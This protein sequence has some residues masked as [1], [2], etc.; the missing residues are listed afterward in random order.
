MAIVRAKAIQLAGFGAEPA[1]GGI[2]LQNWIT[3]TARAWNGR[4]FTAAEIVPVLA[5]SLDLARKFETVGRSLTSA[6]DLQKNEATRNRA[7][8]EYLLGLMQQ[9]VS[10]PYRFT[11]THK[12]WTDVKNATM[13]PVIWLS[14]IIEVHGVVLAARAGLVSEVWESIKN[15]PANVVGVAVGY[16]VDQA[17]DAL[18]LALKPILPKGVPGWV[19]PVVIGVVGLAGAAWL[20]SKFKRVTA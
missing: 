19:A 9:Q 4:T 2:P 5:K 17:K 6:T 1:A 11:W 8:L 20:Y 18:D 13:A 14:G 15:L 3:E 16:V 10:N 7:Q 12:T